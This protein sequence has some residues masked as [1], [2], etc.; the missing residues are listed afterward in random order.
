MKKYKICNTCIIDNTY[1]VNVSFSN[2][3]C[4]YCINFENNISLDDKFCVYLNPIFFNNFEHLLYSAISLKFLLGNSIAIMRF[5][6]L[7][8]FFAPNKKLNS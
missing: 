2:G 7:N 8:V 6:C 4:S 3:K 1:D 5:F